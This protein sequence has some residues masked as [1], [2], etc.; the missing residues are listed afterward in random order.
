MPSSSRPEVMLHSQLHLLNL[1]HNPLSVSSLQA[2]ENA[3]RDNSLS[4]LWQLFLAGS[5]TSDADTNAAWLSTFVEA[6][7]THCP[8]LGRLELSENN[9]GV[10]G[11]SALAG[12]ISKLHHLSQSNDRLNVTFLFKV[13]LNKTNLGDE[14]LCAFVESLE[15]FH[16]FNEVKLEDNGLHADGISSLA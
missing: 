13:Y 12:V 6:L 10:P 9:L 7:S 5:L 4:L 1:S 15:C 3:L 16:H 11:A 8:C 14:G 2:L